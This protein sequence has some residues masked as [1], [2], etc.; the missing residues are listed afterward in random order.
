MLLLVHD[1]TKRFDQRFAID[2]PTFRVFRYQHELAIYTFEYDWDD[3]NGLETELADL[4]A[5][6]HPDLTGDR[7]LVPSAV[8]WLPTNNKS[9]ILPHFYA[10]SDIVEAFLSNGESVDQTQIW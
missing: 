1:R 3:E 10:E 7:F 9:I 2:S 6:Q 4:V 8:L 5:Q